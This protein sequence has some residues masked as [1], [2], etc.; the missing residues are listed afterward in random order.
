MAGDSFF[1]PRLPKLKWSP[2]I[3]SARRGKQQRSRNSSF[4]YLNNFIEFFSTPMRK[5]FPK[6]LVNRKARHTC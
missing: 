5:M 3:K 1:N 2:P 6:S 4:S